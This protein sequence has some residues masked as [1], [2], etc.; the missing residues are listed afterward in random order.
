MLPT[1][2]FIL[3]CNNIIVFHSL[4]LPKMLSRTGSLDLQSRHGNIL[5]CGEV[6]HALYLHA[7]KRDRLEVNRSALL[8]PLKKIF[9]GLWFVC[10]LALFLKVVF[11]LPQRN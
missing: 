11:K 4:V 6:V 7:K 8:H 5:G 2:F 10:G 1:P 9:G 3:F